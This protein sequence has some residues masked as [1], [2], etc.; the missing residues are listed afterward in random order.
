M[1]ISIGVCSIVMHIMGLLGVQRMLVMDGNT[2]ASER[3]E[4]EGGSLCG[5]LDQDK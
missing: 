3:G 2:N 5:D 1:G 4:S